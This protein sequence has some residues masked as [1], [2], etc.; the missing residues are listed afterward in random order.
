MRR[1]ST[2]QRNGTENGS[3]TNPRYLPMKRITLSMDF[4]LVAVAFGIACPALQDH[5]WS[6]PVYS[7]T[8]PAVPTASFA[9]NDSYST[10]QRVADNFSLIGSDPLTIRS[11]RFIGTS[12][13]ISQ[14][15]D[16]FRVVFLEDAAGIPGPPLTGGD[17]AIGSAFRRI[18]TGGELL[19]G[20]GVPI[21]YVINFPNAISLNPDT[22]YW[23]SIVNDLLPTSGWSWARSNGGLD[24]TIA[25][26]T[27][28][29]ITGPW[30]LGSSS[31]GM[32]FELNDQVIPEPSSF[33]LVLL[34]IAA[35]V[36]PRFLHP[37]KEHS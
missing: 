2:C 37:H 7:Q 22:I 20:V 16:D 30:T 9:S 36:L 10:N 13:P 23:I 1:T 4:L 21:E 28:D 5:A 35:S 33:V 31:G 24:L 25:S 17:F 29:I 26:T 32:W 14:R 11:L 12:G 8:T 3:Q 6:A 18:P 34:A 15:S 19:N 27:S